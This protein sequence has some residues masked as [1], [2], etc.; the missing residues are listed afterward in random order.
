MLAPDTA[1]QLTAEFLFSAARYSEIPCSEKREFCILGR[2]NVGKSS[3][4]N[5]VFAD[6]RLARVSKT[7]GKTTLANF[8]S[9]SD[10][11]VWVDLPG[12]GHA[13]KA[14][15]EQIRWS[16][17]VADYCEER[18][19]LRGVIWL[20][21]SRHPGLGIDKEAFAWLSSL[22]LPVLTVLTK[23]DKLTRQEQAAAAKAFVDLVPVDPVP[24]LFS[25]AGEMSRWVFWDHF[26]AW[27]GSLG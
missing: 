5:H 17:L 20:C 10:D 11:S 4:L 1:K 6:N 12:Y 8:F 16:R 13:Q 27:A 23:A 25:N 15:T 22:G 14:R 2:S 9:I 19:N 18:K 24:M 21:D 7:P 3:F 26:C